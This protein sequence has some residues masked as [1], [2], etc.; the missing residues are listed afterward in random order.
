MSQ[1]T[2]ENAEVLSTETSNASS[3][4]MSL[5]GL[6]GT[7]VYDALAK[8]LRTH[9]LVIS[10]I[11]YLGGGG[12]G[13]LVKYKDKVGMLT[14]THVLIHYLDSREIFSPFQATDDP[15]FF[16]NDHIQIKKIIYLDTE[17]G[18]WQLDKAD[19]YP[20]NTLDICLIELDVDV[21][22]NV[23]Q[24]S[25]KKAVDL[26][27]YK[28]NYTNNFD[29]YSSSNK[30]WCWAMDGAPRENVKQ[31]DNNIL[32]S[33]YDGLHV[34][35]GRYRSTPLVHVLPSFDQTAD[36]C[37]HQLGPTLDPLPNRF[38][39][40][41]GAGV[42]QVKFEGNKGKPSAIHELF[43]SGVVVSEGISSEEV[44]EELASRGP[45]SL[46]DIFLSYIDSIS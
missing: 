35:G 15:T 30:D 39:G 20:E 7:P 3:N 26:S 13:T 43:F 8:G 6:R 10:P 25:G 14:A 31:D 17:S 27:V 4:T 45:T 29:L 34:A 44:S 32:Q 24:R 19:S 41:S 9:S 21:F 12:S 40:M 28:E 5:S 38:A 42:W 1:K 37:V 2:V 22:E 23:L 46:Y 33:R 18:L 11:P 16:I 36:L